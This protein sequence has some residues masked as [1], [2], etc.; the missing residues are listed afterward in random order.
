MKRSANS[1][2]G[3]LAFS[4]F[5]LLAAG[6]ARLQAQVFPE[7]NSPIQQEIKSREEKE[8]LAAF[9]YN[10]QQYDK[11]VELYRELFNENPTHL[12]YTYYFYCLVALGEYAEAEKAAKSMTRTA[13]RTVR[14]QVDIG[15]IYQLQDKFEKAYK[16]YDELIDG[17]KPVKADIQELANAFLGRQAFDFAVKT[18]LKGR[19]LLSHNESFHEDLARVYEITGDYGAM[20]DEYLELILEEPAR[21]EFVQGR[22]QNTLSK[23]SE[24]TISEML[25]QSLLKISQKNPD[26]REF[27]EMLLWLSVQQ[28]DFEFALVQAKSLDKRFGDNGLQVFNLAH[29]ALSNGDYNTS[30][31][32]FQY[33]LDKGPAN[34]YYLESLTGNLKSRFLGITSGLTSGIQEY[35]NLEIEYIRTLDQFGY[36]SRTIFLMRDLAHLQAFYL[37]D[38]DAAVELLD[39]AIA[40][41]GVNP[42][43]VAEC[44]LELGDILLYRGEVWDA[45][46]LYSQVDKAL[47]NEPLGSEA[48]FRNAKLSYYIGEFDWARA[49]LD[50]LKAATSKRI[51]N[52]ALELSLLISGNM[53]TDSTYTSLKY[54]SRA[55]LLHYMHDYREA[56]TVLDTIAMLGLYHPLDDEVLFKKAMIYLDLKQFDLADSLLAKVADVYSEDILADNAL[57]IRAELQEKIFQNRTLAMD[58]YQRILTDCPGSLFVTESRK[59]YRMLRGDQLQAP[60]QSPTFMP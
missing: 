52:D 55:D 9:Y 15:Y 11:A 47:K 51:A 26:N 6:P 48:K 3:F 18:Y 38:M 39:K 34:P 36:N 10:D 7:V 60:E 27:S 19:E 16:I 24:G 21:V 45:S 43:V 12:Y 8:K 37:E 54:Y 59:R 57:F 13:Q 46:L 4:F 29:L 32:A 41:P 1:L 28:K 20:I 42:N 49:Q 50:V 23:D 2:K 40:I 53:D 31:A 17:L 44:K 35:R 22:L 58:L 5:L 30:A 33:I 56:L 14:Y 25:R